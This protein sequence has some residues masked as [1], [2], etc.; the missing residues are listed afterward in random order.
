VAR[1]QH[2]STAGFLFLAPYIELQS[3]LE[4]AFEG[5][6]PPPSFPLRALRSHPRPGRPSEPVNARIGVPGF[7]MI[8]RQQRCPAA[9]QET[10]SVGLGIS[11]QI[12]DMIIASHNM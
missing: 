2:E 6:E 11:A 10:S 5:F 9:R 7:E 3:R 4:P 8:K 1:A 12:P